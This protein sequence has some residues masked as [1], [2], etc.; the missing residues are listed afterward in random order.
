MPSTD[1]EVRAMASKKQQELTYLQMS[2]P[3]GQNSAKITKLNWIGLNKRQELDTGELSA[4]C[5]ISTSAAPY[6]IPSEK[7]QIYSDKQYENPISMF[8]FDDFLLVVYRDNKKIK[9]DY[10]TKQLDIY[11]GVLNS[12]ASTT[13]NRPRSIVKFNVYDDPSSVEFDGGFTSKL[14]I[15]PDKKSM[16]FE[17]DSDFTPKAMDMTAIEFTNSE[18]PY[19][20]ESDADT[21]CYY[22][23]TYNQTYY[24]YNK[25]SLTWYETILNR[26][27]EFSAVTVHLSRV[28]G[29]K[30]DKVYASAFND[31]AN[32]NLDT[33]DETNTANAWFTTSQSNT[34]SKGNFVGIT[35]YGGQV[36]CFKHDF[37]HEIYNTKNPFRLNDVFAEGTIDNRT[38]QDV[39]GKLI[40]VSAD[41]VK[42]Y[43]GSNPR[44]ISYNLNIDKIYYAVSGTDKRKYYLYCGTR[45]KDHNLFVYDTYTDEWAEESIDFEVK[46]FVHNE[47]GM[48]LLGSDGY[49]YKMDTRKYSHNWSFE[50]DFSTQSNVDIKHIAKISMLVD[51][52]KGADFKVYAVYD[53]EEFDENTSQLLYSSSGYG[54]KSVRVKT[55]QTANYGFKLHFC[56]FGYV[57]FY[58]MCVSVTNGGDLYVTI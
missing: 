31:Y 17:T 19:T 14:L 38:I 42:I 34:K 4:E 26:V 12:N 25:D 22:Y 27:P 48:F 7:R 39:D 11:T 35:T 18:E 9:I 57:K 50:T 30:D 20:P 16:D 55:R 2:V 46:S 52:K 56:G 37:M 23:N 10:I 24:A 15:Y 45:E 29:I 32:F 5:N 49:V 51:I 3:T 47:N 40:F 41:G 13:D 44:I 33:A 8:G 43:T 6:L 54:K 28:F 36:I 53:D 21:D 1:C 58:E